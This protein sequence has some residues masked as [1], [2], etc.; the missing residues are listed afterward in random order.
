[1]RNLLTKNGSFEIIEA[2]DGFEA[3]DAYRMET[4]DLVLMDI[5]MPRLGGIDTLSKIMD[6][7]KDAVIVMLSAM[8]QN[9]I[10]KKCLE[11][12]AVDYIVKPYDEEKMLKIIRKIVGSRD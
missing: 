3:I 2:R 8:G 4:P 12:G 5:V 1:M 7:D 10:V 9:E 6:I 11:L